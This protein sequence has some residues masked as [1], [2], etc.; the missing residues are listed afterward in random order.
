MRKRCSSFSGD[1]DRIDEKEN[2]IQIIS[3]CVTNAHACDLVFKEL[4]WN[5]LS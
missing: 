4:F 2:E 3:G 5:T 1:E